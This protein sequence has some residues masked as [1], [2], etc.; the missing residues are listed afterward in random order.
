LQ[1]YSGKLEKL[2]STAPLLR[3]L[4]LK[5]AGVEVLDLGKT[6]LDDL[7]LDMSGIRKLILPKDI[8]SLKLYG[9]IQPDLQIDDS[10]CDGKLNLEIWIR[11]RGY[12]SIRGSV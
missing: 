3:T 9:K 11:C 12:G 10:L 2:I 5:K 8:R 7:E 4:R 1:G 6:C